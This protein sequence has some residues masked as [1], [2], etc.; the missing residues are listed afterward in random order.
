MGILDR[1]LNIL[2]SAL[3][4]DA[5]PEAFDHV[6]APPKYSQWTNHAGGYIVCS[7]VGCK[8]KVDPAIDDHDCCGRC[9][10]GRSCRGHAA[11]NYDGPGSF[12]HGYWETIL[13]SGVCITCGEP[14]ESH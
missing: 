4:V 2:G 7:H 14:P 11:N 5:T 13:E 9:T 3:E 10:R 12:Y 6:D 1:L 8:K